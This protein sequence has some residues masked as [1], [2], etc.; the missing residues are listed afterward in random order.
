MILADLFGMGFG[1]GSAEDGEILAVH[2]YGA[3]VDGAVAGD[4]AIAGNGPLVHAEFGAPVLD[5]HVPF[6]EGL[7]V[8][9]QLEALARRQL[10]LL[11]LGLDAVPRRRPGG[12]AGVSLPVAG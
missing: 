2:E 7:G 8:E 9:Q 6:L 3:A 1:Q 11:V 12:R 5:E 4:H 10:A